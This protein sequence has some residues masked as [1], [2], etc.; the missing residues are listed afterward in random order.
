[1]GIA[2]SKRKKRDLFN[3]FQHCY[4]IYIYISLSLSPSLS[5]RVLYYEYYTHAIDTIHMYVYIYIL[6]Q[7]VTTHIHTSIMK[8]E[9]ACVSLV[10]AANLKISAMPRLAILT[11][12]KH[13][14]EG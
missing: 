6:P 2:T 5:I 4:D 3:L 11:S 1:M 14:C 10:L 8:P 9:R 7:M 13:G 12:K